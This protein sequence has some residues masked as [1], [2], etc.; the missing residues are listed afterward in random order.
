M[1]AEVTTPEYQD[2]GVEKNV[3]YY[4]KVR[5]LTKN[6]MRSDCSPV[7]SGETALTPNPPV[8]LKA[9]GHVKSI[10]L[11]LSPSPAASDDP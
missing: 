7:I 1:I 11:L 3:T 6:G 9:E 2:Q 4:Y 10:R 8:I 5:A